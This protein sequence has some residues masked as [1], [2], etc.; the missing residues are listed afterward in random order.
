MIPAVPPRQTPTSRMAARGFSDCTFLNQPPQF[1]A[2]VN[3]YQGIV[4]DL[5]VN[6]H[7]SLIALPGGIIGCRKG[8]SIMKT[9]NIEIGTTLIGWPFT[10]INTGFIKQGMN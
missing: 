1:V 9:V 8:K 10:D 6:F 7:K 4:F 2:A 3:I 5:P